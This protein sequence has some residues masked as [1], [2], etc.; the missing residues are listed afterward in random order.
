MQAEVCTSRV[1]RGLQTTL[2]A[3]LAQT[4]VGKKLV[5]VPC[6]DLLRPAELDLQKPIKSTPILLSMALVSTFQFF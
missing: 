4:K 5:E 3:H 2:S 6:I 1:Q